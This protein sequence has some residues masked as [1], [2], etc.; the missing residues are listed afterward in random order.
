MGAKGQNICV[1]PRHH[2]PK[3]KSLCQLS[4]GLARA[5]VKGGNK[6]TR[7]GRILAP[8]RGEHCT[9]FSLT[10]DGSLSLSV[11]DENHIVGLVVCRKN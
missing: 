8:Y 4:K 6:Y 1:P 2:P 5:I 10:L 7:L 11:R 3:N 9:K